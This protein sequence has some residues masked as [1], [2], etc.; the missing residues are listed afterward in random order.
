MTDTTIAT[1]G[2]K[3]MT[4]STWRDETH[5]RGMLLKLISQAPQRQPRVSLRTCTLPRRRKNRRWSMKP[6]AEPSIMTWR[7]FNSPL[8]R[9]VEY[10]LPQSLP[11]RTASRPWCCST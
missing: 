8:A 3:G 11:W 6:F 7:V 9:S 10:P 1:P 2:I 4:R 5:L